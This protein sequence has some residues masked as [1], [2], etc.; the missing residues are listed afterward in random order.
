M[1]VVFFLAIFLARVVSN[2]Y[3]FYVKFLMLLNF[4]YGLCIINF[5]VLFCAFLFCIAIFDPP[6]V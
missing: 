6:W 3:I 1:R 2:V 5:S 4:C